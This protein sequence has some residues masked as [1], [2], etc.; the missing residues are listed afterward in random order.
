MLINKRSLVMMSVLGFILVGNVHAQED[1]SNSMH[2]SFSKDGWAK[3]E[4][5]VKEIF[6]KLNLSDEQKKQL[7]ENK[8]KTR[9]VMKALHEQ[10]KSSREAMHQELMKTDLD[11]AKI[12][13]IQNQLKTLQAQMI[14]ARLN[15]I[16]EVRKILSA[17]QFKK[18]NELMD[19]E[20]ASSEHESKEMKE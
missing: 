15:S 8:T 20:K 4:N 17:E 14:D 7:E 18:F 2:A 16:L 12:T 13:E 19:K 3:K 6:D 1:A 10:M 5:R 11:M 9:D